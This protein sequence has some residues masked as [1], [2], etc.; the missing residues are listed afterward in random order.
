MTVIVDPERMK[1]DL[2]AIFRADGS[3]A[4]EAEIV[5]DHLVEASLTGHDSHGVVRTP[6]YH[7][8]LKDGSIVPGLSPGIVWDGGAILHLDGRDGFGQAIARQAT[9]LAIERAKVH[10]ACV[11]ALKRANHVGRIGAWAEQAAAEGL[12]SV[13]F[14]NVSGAAVVA[15]FGARERIASTNPVCVGVP[16]PAGGDFV[17]DFA[18]SLVA[19]GKALV[20]AQGG[21]PVPADAFIGPDGEITGDPSALY[22]ETI[23]TGAPN[24]R[25]GGG[26]LRTMGE[27]KGS[28]L[29]LA[30]DLLAGALAGGGLSSGGT[31]GRFGNSMLSIVIDPARFDHGFADATAELVEMVRAARP[32][33]GVDEVLA[34]GDRERAT[35]AERLANGLPVADGTVAAIRAVMDEL[36]LPVTFA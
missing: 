15:P 14:V 9:A 6:R 29:A 18:T 36:G 25:A 7:E 16:N 23:A 20:A 19:E 11:M 27:H 5:A 33:A 10:G 8:A 2:L 26:A 24:P 13:H 32:A 17:L 28:G 22:G 3:P 35:K 31:A 12:V 21:K 34:P 1:A 30:C 4:E